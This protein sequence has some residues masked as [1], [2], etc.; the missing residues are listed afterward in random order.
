MIGETISHYRIVS[1]LGAGGMGEVYL[2]E[3]TQLRRT[4]ALKFLPPGYSADPLVLERFEREARA[5]AA[6]NH[7]NIITIHEVAMHGDRPYI[8]MEHVK[9]SPL[10]EYIKREAP[11]IDAILDLTIQIAEGLAKAHASDIVHRDLKPANIVVDED[12]R[13]KILDFGLARQAGVTRITKEASTL[14]TLFYMSPEQTRDNDVDPRSDIFSLGTVL[15]EMIT[16]QLPFEGDHQAAVMYAI[17]SVDPQ[18]LSRYS[19][20]AT[21]AL[22][23]IVSKMLAKDPG[24]RYQSAADLVADL[25]R[26][27]RVTQ[28]GAYSAAHP[29]ASGGSR[30][31]ILKIAIPVIAVVAAAVIILKPFSV[32]ITPDQTAEAGENSLAVMYFE[33]MVE[34]DDEKRTGEIMANLL[35]T[36][37]SD[38]DQLRV[39]SSQRLYDILKGLDKEGTRAVDRDTATRV[40]TRAGARSMLLGSILSAEPMVVTWQLVDVTT[41][42]IEDSDRVD[43]RDGETV[44][45]LV[46][47]MTVEL[48]ESLAIRGDPAGEPVSVAAKTT[49]SA[50]AYRLYIEGMELFWKNFKVD[51]N[52]RFLAAL[53]IDSTMAMAAFRLALPTNFLITERARRA[54]IQQA[55]RHADKVTERDR[56]MINAVYAAYYGTTSEVIEEFLAVVDKDPDDKEAWFFLSG[57]YWMRAGNYDEALRA[58]FKVTEIDPDFKLAYNQQAYMYINLRRYQEALEAVDNYILV[59]PD[60]PNPYDTRAEIYGFMGRIDDAIKWYAKAFELSS[61]FAVARFAMADMY[62]FKGDEESGLAIY[63]ELEEHP[64]PH[65]RGFARLSSTN[66]AVYRGQLRTSLDLLDRGI[67]EDESEGYSGAFHYY[68]YGAKAFQYALL[69]DF[70]QAL[71]HIRRSNEIATINDGPAS[72][73]WTSE[74]ELLAWSGDFDAAE[75]LLAAHSIDVER[76][77]QDARADYV[78]SQ[79]IIEYYR[80]NYDRACISFDE[81][82]DKLSNFYYEFFRAMAYARAGRPTIAASAFDTIVHSYAGDRAK[83]GFVSTSV[84]Y[85]A[86]VAYE[87]AGQR[88]KAIAAYEEFLEICSQPDPELQSVEDARRRLEALRRGS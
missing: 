6:L 13:P 75:A 51:Y 19:K 55:K 27:R 8:V 50:E 78:F 46:D 10:D 11:S 54:Y 79:G 23:R 42:D 30:G 44:F 38:T 82:V 16:R 24:E 43:G 52:Q 48:K 66:A 62:L 60:E 81:S 77:N 64:H 73:D 71:V 9:G 86:G 76:V 53:E 84:H 34:P 25:K 61:D 68:K 65:W 85:H 35:I 59:S 45:S 69:G 88:D 5:A 41:G 18:P 87:A 12:G 7:P 74:I 29:I 40:A 56:H 63:D 26:E 70:E 33:N 57:A 80:G 47:R 17:T 72:A 32:E 49:T 2:A 1:R 4:V 14:G 15:Y 39:V 20:D 22:E 31:K 3:D 67:A 36:A 28:S 83:S 37:L 21:P 58:A